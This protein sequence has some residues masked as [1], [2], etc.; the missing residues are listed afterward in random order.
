MAS[1]AQVLVVHERI[2][3]WARHL[4]ARLSDWPVGVVE[5]RSS[6]DLESALF[7]SICPILLIDL[8]RRPRAGLEDLDRAIRVAADA[9]ALVLD[10][11]SH[12][13]V[14]LLARELGAAHVISGPVPPP[15]VARLFVRWLSLAERRAAAAGWSTTLPKAPEPEPWNWLSPLLNPWPAVAPRPSRE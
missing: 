6:S 8:G 11:A 10:P 9:L 2:G 15:V 3:T 14:P 7:G 5:T 1:Q 13:G 4:R 12:D